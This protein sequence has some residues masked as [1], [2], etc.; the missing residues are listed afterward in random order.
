MIITEEMVMNN[1]PTFGIALFSKRY[2]AEKA[3]D[4]ATI[5][6]YSYQKMRD[7]ID[8]GTSS[9]VNYS[10]NMIT[11]YY[12]CY[13]ALVEAS[14]RENQLKKHNDKLN[15]LKSMPSYLRMQDDLSELDSNTQAMIIDITRKLISL[16]D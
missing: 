1:I 14:T 13:C 10:R 3:G 5:R 16:F 7:D 4:K 2:E 6:K 9:R 11:S 15:K 12:K 8:K